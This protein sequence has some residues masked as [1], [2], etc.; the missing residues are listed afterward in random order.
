MKFGNNKIID[1][2]QKH[3]CYL[4][5][6]RLNSLLYVMYNSMKI[7]CKAFR[8]SAFFFFFV[9]TRKYSNLHAN[10]G[11][12]FVFSIET[13]HNFHAHVKCIATDDYKWLTWNWCFFF[14]RVFFP[15]S[16]INHHYCFNRNVLYKTIIWE[17]VILAYC[18][19]CKKSIKN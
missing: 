10:N 11:M 1:C 14:F 16:L 5:N 15:V 18:I 7:S 6:A 12:Y 3:E 9:P 8:F 4:R 13:K 17:I 2:V 19:W